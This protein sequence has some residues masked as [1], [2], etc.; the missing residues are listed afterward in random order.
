MC[1]NLNEVAVAM[2]R[3]THDVPPRK[4]ILLQFAKIAKICDI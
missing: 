4:Q 3:Y 1:G 2:K